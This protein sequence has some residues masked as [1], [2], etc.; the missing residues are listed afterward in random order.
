[1]LAVS[2][3]LNDMAEALLKLGADANAANSKGFTAAVYA[4][5]HGNSAIMKPLQ[6]AG[7][8]LDKR[9]RGYT[10]IEW[11][12]L[13]GKVDVVSNLIERGVD[14]N[15]QGYD[16]YT[17][18]TFAALNGYPVQLV[19]NLLNNGADP[20][21]KTNYGDTPLI[22]AS[23]RG[24]TEIVDNLI[25]GGADLNAQN[26]DGQTALMS[27]ANYKNKGIMLDIVHLLLKAG[28]NRRIKDEK[29]R[30]AVFYARRLGYYDVVKVLRN[31]RIGRGK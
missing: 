7:A 25:K 18:L 17:A 15:I 23:I 4:A 10:P 21:L 14:L 27:A 26:N 13:K 28:A 24:H 19:V 5:I 12:A 30:R 6:E 22:L 9:Y 20:D 16:G 3:Q 1:M 8:K 31:H 2:S 11:A 29:G